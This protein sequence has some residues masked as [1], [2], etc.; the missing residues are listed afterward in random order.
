MTFQ[1]REL[2]IIDNKLF[3]YRSI[4]QFLPNT[5]VERNIYSRFTYDDITF[6]NY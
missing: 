1:E 4:L 5:I 3:F 6:N 2:L